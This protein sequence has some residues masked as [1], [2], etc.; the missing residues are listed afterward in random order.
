MDGPML[1]AHSIVRAQI[2]V[3]REICALHTWV[4]CQSSAQIIKL[5]CHVCTY[6][7]SY[8][9][10]N[11]KW[12]V[13]THR[14]TRFSRHGK[15]CLSEYLV[16]RDFPSPLVRFNHGWEWGLYYERYAS[17]HFTCTK[18]MIIGKQI[19]PQVLSE[20]MEVIKKHTIA[21]V[22]RIFLLRSS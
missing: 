14:T 9:L 3:C 4:M 8:L 20:T 22:L 6:I 15:L 16:N 18:F 5:L 21:K 12:V 10:H 1:L 2:L 19:C 7:S 11:P 13:F 17:V